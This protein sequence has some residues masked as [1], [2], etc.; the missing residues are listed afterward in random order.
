MEEKWVIDIR[1]QC[2]EANVPF[3]FKQW[4]GIRNKRGGDKALLGR[5]WRE[6]PPGSRSENNK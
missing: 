3:F 2:Q 4:G 6:L 1:D 5:L